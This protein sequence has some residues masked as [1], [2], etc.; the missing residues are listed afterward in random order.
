MKIA[1]FGDSFI[2]GLSEGHSLLPEV[3]QGMLGEKYNT[4]LD[5][6]G[7]SGTGPW[8]SFFDFLDYMKEQKTAPDV[9]I[10][11]WSEINRIYNNYVK[12]L[13]YGTAMNKMNDYMEPNRQI[14]LTA[15]GYYKYFAS[16]EKPN[17]EMAALMNMFDEMTLE[18]PTTK[19][20]NLHCF[21]WLEGSQWWDVYD[22]IDVSDIKYFHRFR[23]C[24]E[25]RPPLIYMSRRDQWPSDIS[26]ETRE[27]HLTTKMH[28]LL[29]DAIIECIDNYKPG[30]LVEIPANKIN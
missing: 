30:K 8:S 9:V 23:N 18:F 1:G 25:V 5:F 16:T 14:Y 17:H 27:C 21:S 26:K 28:R 29:T 6:R 20:I 22:T 19:F 13:N 11:A 12:V 15:L 3:Y 4:Y 7:V 10:F 24:A 2:L